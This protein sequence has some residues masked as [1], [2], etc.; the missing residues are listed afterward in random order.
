MNEEISQIH[1]PEDLTSAKRKTT[2]RLQDKLIDVYTNL[3][4]RLSF[5]V[6]NFQNHVVAGTGGSFLL[7]Y[8]WFYAV[9]IRL[10]RPGLMYGGYLLV[11]TLG[12]QSLEISMSS[13]KSI[14]AILGLA[15]TVDDKTIVGTPFPNQAIYI[16][17]LAFIA[18]SE[19]YAN[20]HSKAQLRYGGG[21]KD[22]ARCGLTPRDTS[23]TA[24]LPTSASRFLLRLASK[25]NYETCLYTEDILKRYWRGIG[26]ILSTMEQKAAGITNTDPSEESVDPHSE[27][28]LPGSGMLRRLMTEKQSCRRED[29]GALA[30][31]R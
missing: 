7:I 1:Q 3:D 23:E 31:P 10:H 18:E 20:V 24:E 29:R 13:A 14:T 6:S 12:E 9:I 25:R 2:K 21:E 11:Y 5:N 28:D 16:A 4:D 27:I 19:M 26:W 8:I 15:A 22:Q 17:G 30:R